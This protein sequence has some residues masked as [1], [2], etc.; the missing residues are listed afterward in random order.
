MDEWITPILTVFVLGTLF[1]MGIWHSVR[2]GECD[3]RFEDLHVRESATSEPSSGGYHD[4]ITYHLYC[5]RCDQ[6]LPL[7]YSKCKENMSELVRRDMQAEGA[8][9]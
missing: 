9:E 7:T 2:L 4:H 1:G 3:H 8:L 5:R 6:N